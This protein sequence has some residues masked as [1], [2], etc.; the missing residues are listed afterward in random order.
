MLLVGAGL[1]ARAINRRS[2]AR[3]AE[4]GVRDQRGRVRREV[5]PR[6]EVRSHARG[7]GAGRR[8]WEGWGLGGRG[9]RQGS[10]PSWR[11]RAAGS[12][13]RPLS[14]HRRRRRRRHWH[15]H[16]PPRRARVGWRPLGRGE[17]GRGPRT[18]WLGRGTLEATRPGREHVGVAVGA[19]P[20][21]GAHVAAAAAAAAA[22]ARATAETTVRAAAGAAAVAAATGGAGA[23]WLGRAAFEAAR[24]G[25]EDVGVAVGARPVTRTH[26]PAAAAAA[27]ADEDGGRG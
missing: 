26:V 6:S 18:G 2:A 23:G 25:R 24:L 14:S 27:C 10:S 8:V 22:A 15:R 20:V 19:R 16:L 21:A 17:R 4:C 12:G 13:A 1:R 11:A 9:A 3:S 5:H 7:F